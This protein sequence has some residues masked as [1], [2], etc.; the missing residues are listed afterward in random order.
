[1]TEAGSLSRGIPLLARLE[2]EEIRSLDGRGSVLDLEPG[3]L[4]FAEG[5]SGNELYVV[6]SGVVTAR[7]SLPDGAERDVASFLPGDFFG[8]MG[9][10]EGRP[11]SAAC[12]TAARTRLWCLSAEGLRRFGADRPGA[13]V[14][15]LRTLAAIVT[16]RLREKS[17]LLSSM[18]VWGE[19][20]GRRAFTDDATGLGNRR[21]FDQALA[22]G[23]EEARRGGSVLTVVMADV[24]GFRRINE[25]LTTTTGDA[26]LREISTLFR[27]EMEAPDTLAR[28]G[29]DE[30]A[31]VLPDRDETAAERICSR[32][33]S[34]VA[35]S[36]R[37]RALGIV[38]PV[39]V[40]LGYACARGND[41]A[42]P[43]TLVAR[44]D[45]ALYRAKR[46]GKNGVAAG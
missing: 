25:S 27:A 9:I 10:F 23:C 6:L 1:M 34:A 40:S 4:V 13:A 42:V 38:L 45:A 32:I 44:A 16:R 8:E 12:R 21:S 29:G 11:R 17:G 5:E 14:R 3:T 43:A 19:Q 35:K 33:C 41:P 28:Y 26:I 37:W 31:M 39:T 36:P 18:V 7:G 20:A 30:L 15:L 2:D 24:D 22:D 46:A